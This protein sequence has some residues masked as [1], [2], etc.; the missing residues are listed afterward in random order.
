MLGLST[1]EASLPSIPVLTLFL[2]HLLWAAAEAA[3]SPGGSLVRPG[4]NPALTMLMETY[5]KLPCIWITDLQYSNSSETKSLPR[6]RLSLSSWCVED[7][8]TRIRA[9][10]CFL[11]F[12]LYLLSPLNK[13]GQ[14]ANNFFTL[15]LQQ[16]NEKLYLLKVET[17]TTSKTQQNDQCCSC[18]HRRQPEEHLAEL[19]TVNAFKCIYK[20]CLRKH[21]GDLGV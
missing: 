19:T 6:P 10:V 9:A 11:S 12:H 3:F 4:T 2:Q 15:F 13:A 18:F 16:P 7:A 5:S 21:F 17:F 1:S 14:L 20:H 8:A